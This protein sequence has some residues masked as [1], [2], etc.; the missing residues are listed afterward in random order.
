[1]SSP[2]THVTE[3]EADSCSSKKRNS[4]SLSS[5]LLPGR[6]SSPESMEPA[7]KLVRWTTDLPGGPASDP[8][9]SDSSAQGALK[10]RVKKM[11][12]REQGKRSGRSLKD[13][14]AGE[15][16]EFMEKM[17]LKIHK[18]ARKEL[19][20]LNQ[21]KKLREARNIMTNR[22]TKLTRTLQQAL[23]AEGPSAIVD[24]PR[25]PPVFS[26]GSSGNPAIIDLTE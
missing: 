18:I 9:A 24:A 15:L 13:L 6:P 19:Q 7:K 20:L 16:Q 4:S 1:M 22:H 26:A 17:E 23:Q 12:Q 8:K 14:T 3:R 25:L 2:E 21:S 11:R 10:N 5:P